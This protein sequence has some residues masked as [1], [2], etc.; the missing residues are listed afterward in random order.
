[1]YYYPLVSHQVLFHAPIG[2]STTKTFEICRLP[3]PYNI[4]I[5]SQKLLSSMHFIYP[6]NSDLVLT[7]EKDQIFPNI[8]WDQHAGLVRSP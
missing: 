3:Q 2:N 4:R 6:R 5:L 7:P 1:M 8:A